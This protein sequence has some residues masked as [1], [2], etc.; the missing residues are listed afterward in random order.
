MM[1]DGFGSEHVMLEIILP[2][3][4]FQRFYSITISTRDGEQEYTETLYSKTTSAEFAEAYFMQFIFNEEEWTQIGD[5]QW[6]EVGGY[7]IRK[8]EQ[9]PSDAH[10]DGIIEIVNRPAVQLN[11]LISINDFNFHRQD[12]DIEFVADIEEETFECW[13]Q[14]EPSGSFIVYS[15]GVYGTTGVS[16]LDFESAVEVLNK[17]C[18]LQDGMDKPDRYL[19]RLPIG[20]AARFMY[21]NREYVLF[22]A[23]SGVEVFSG[24]DYDRG[25]IIP[26][27]NFPGVTNFPNSDMWEEIYTILGEDD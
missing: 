4:N 19:K 16:A 14:V 2:E 6:E 3:K 1:N 24:V 17:L 27:M 13:W 7:R 12:A 21:K 9:Y 22:F 5:N 18:T 8:V 26:E 15:S 11:D 20:S 10:G 23:N 25:V